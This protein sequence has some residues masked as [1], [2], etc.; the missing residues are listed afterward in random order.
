MF[1]G[2]SAFPL[3]PLVSGAVDDARFV[4]IVDRLST[5]GVDSI[6]ALGST[7]SAAYLERPERARVAR[8]AVE[9]AGD[10][11]VIVGISA[12]STRAVLDHLD[13]AHEA[14]AAAVLLAPMTYLP[15][16]DDEVF[17]LYEDVASRSSL[18]I[19]VYD[20]PVTTRVEFSDE[21]HARI[22]DLDRV[23]SIKLPPLSTDPVQARARVDGLRALVPESVTIGI[24]GDVLAVEGLIAGCDAWYSVIAGVFPEV[25]LG[26]MREVRAGEPA[27]AREQAARYAPLWALF[28]RYGSL[29][30]AAAIAEELGLTGPTALP[31]PVLGIDPAGRAALVAAL[32]RTGLGA[33]RADRQG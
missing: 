19:V 7:G 26:I 29:R 33:E 6:G 16:D 8:L 3:T 4:R 25:A 18:P 21:L 9:A 5:A 12:L 23:R 17:G 24:S 13:D 10:V 11:P 31:R 30:V 32:A 15:L 22:A 27:S 2:V 20:N 14:G 28:N 1:H